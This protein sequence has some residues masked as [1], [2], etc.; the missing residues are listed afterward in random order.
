[1]APPPTR[2]VPALERIYGSSWST[3]LALALVVGSVLFL[4]VFPRLASGR[5]ESLR[6]EMLELAAPAHQAAGRIER[7]VALEVAAVRGYLLS[8]APQFQ[9]RFREASEDETRATA[10]LQRLATALGGDV[11]DRVAAFK[12]MKEG[13]REPIAALMEGGMSREHYLRDLAAQQARFESIVAALQQVDVAI[14][15]AEDR[16]RAAIAEAEEAEGRWMV[17]ASIVAVLSAVVA[18]AI[19][20]RLRVLTRR[21]RRRADEEQELRVLARTLS[22]ALTANEVV[23]R[24]VDSAVA[25]TRASGA[26]VEQAHATEVAVVATAGEGGPPVGTRVPY[27]GSLTEAILTGRDPE[28]VAALG[29]AMS[30]H[31][32][33]SCP[34]CA[35]LVVPLFAESELLGALILLRRPR[36]PRFD[37]AD[38]AYARIA[39]DLASAALRRVT[40]LEQAQRERAALLASEEQFRAVAET[41][42]VA[43]FVVGL[44]DTVVF[45]NR[46]VERI[47]GYKASELIGRPLATLIPPELRASHRAGVERYV[48]TGE[49]RL[50]WEGVEL[51]AISKDGREVPIEVTLGEF[52]RDGRR[53][54]TA[55]ARDITERRRAEQEKAGLLLR[56]REARERA[57]AAIRT[58]EE[59][60]AIVS[61]DLRN[62][63]NTIAMGAAALKDFSADEA[64][65]ERYV[66]MIQRAIQRMN[67]L[68]EDLLDVMRLE[69]GQKL[70]LNLAP[71]E[72][73][74]MLLE[75]AESFHA[76]AEPRRQAF[77]CEVEPG[78]PPVTAD[79]DRLAQV[80]ANLVGNAL[81]FTPE[82]G[83]VEL[84]A[85]RA[86][87]EVAVAVRDDGPGMSDEELGRIFDP[88]WQAGRTARLGAGLGLTISK[89][90][91]E[92]HGGRLD[93]ES[94]PGQGSTFTFTLPVAGREPAAPGGAEDGSAADPEETTAGSGAG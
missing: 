64:T 91:V 26:Y 82:G 72:L 4:V 13:W 39:G 90:I 53:Y 38:V 88:Y 41:A 19:A 79:R 43:I 48:A 44:D 40:L 54:F 18:G 86:G 76:Q 32:R 8:G 47:F 25:N 37:E 21:A 22:G 9:T 75:L 51:P 71:L 50:S 62:P 67:R 69:G 55:I 74:P 78:L 24:L 28:I 94:K 1:M 23:Q 45:A 3:A 92:S 17:I 49:R 42:Q 61:H 12:R 57:E 36:D 63:L 29:E 31:L 35:A 89:G 20:R 58:R 84:R 7:A 73:A 5:I 81:K 87:H 27:P 34:G 59:V 93:V 56:E 68:I 6:N 60:L 46:P 52:V 10:D 16:R 83:R 30:G 33:T 77:V 15:A 66:Q 70:A 80:I 85:A 2:R 11:P 65:R 14:V